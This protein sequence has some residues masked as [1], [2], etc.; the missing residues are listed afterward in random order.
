MLSLSLVAANA[1]TWYVDDD[2]T[3]ANNGTSWADAWTNVSRITVSALSAGD[4]VQ[5]A[6]GNYWDMPNLNKSGTAGS[7]I[8]I[9]MAQDTNYQG[10]VWL[11]N[12][13]TGLNLYAAFV[14]INGALDTDFVVP[15]AVNDIDVL[16]NNIGLHLVGPYGGITT[17]GNRDG[18]KLQWIHIGSVGNMD[19]SFPAD[20]EAPENGIYLG[21]PLT[22]AVIAYVWFQNTWFGDMINSPKTHT[23]LKVHDCLFYNMGDDPVQ[24]VG[25]F[26]L[27]RCKMKG[28]VWGYASGH[29][30]MIQTWGSNI[31][32]HHNI[33]TDIGPAFDGNGPNYT[34]WNA[35]GG[36]N[37]A[38]S[39][40]SFCYSNATSLTNPFLTS[41]TLGTK[42]SDFAGWLGYRFRTGTNNVVIT[43]LGRVYSTGETIPRVLRLY[44]STGDTATGTLRYSVTWDPSTD[45][46]VDGEM[47]YVTNG[48]YTL[49]A[50]TSYVLV[51]GEMQAGEEWYDYDTAVTSDLWAGGVQ[52]AVGSVSRY[53]SWGLCQFSAELDHDFMIYNN[54]LYDQSTNAYGNPGFGM[55]F[56]AYNFTTYYNEVHT[57]S[58][59]YFLNNLMQRPEGRPIGHTFYWTSGSARGSNDLFLMTNYVFG[60]N[61]IVDSYRIDSSQLGGNAADFPTVSYPDDPISG[62]DTGPFLTDVRVWTNVFCG[63]NFKLSGGKTNYANI[64]LA[65]ADAAFV[66]NQTNLPSFRRFDGYRNLPAQDFRLNRSDTVALDAGMNLTSLTNMMPDLDRDIDWN[67]RP[68][69]GAWDIGP[70]EYGSES[71]ILWLDFDDTNWLSSGRI[72]DMSG[73]ENH[74]Y[75]FGYGGGTNWPLVVESTNASSAASFNRWTNTSLS[76]GQEG[77]Y[78]GITNLTDFATNNTATFAVWCLFLSDTNTGSWVNEN[79]QSFVD[80]GY[81]YAGGMKWGKNGTKSVTIYYWTNSINTD[82]SAKEIMRWPDQTDTAGGDT[83]GWHHYAWTY[84]G[85]SVSAYYDGSFLSNST[86]DF[87]TATNLLMKGWL[88]VGCKTHYTVADPQETP[89]FGD[90]D[91]PN[92]GWLHANID[93]LRIYNTALSAQEINRV[94]LGGVASADAG[95]D[96]PPEPPAQTQTRRTRAGTLRFAF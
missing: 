51:G 23:N 17:S 50:N 20:G 10:H 15:D 75:Q 12:A 19:G 4:D 53:S 85:T 82:G 70:Y 74:A 21:D 13:T 64:V 38:W 57:I 84:N 93:D 24:V 81:G 56:D 35:R 59:V 94:Y 90:D 11:T 76:V 49:T 69:A 67:V 16:T 7:P 78:A 2:A 37:Q 62:S 71:L 44:E 47:L 14:E 34:E 26:E 42:R 22:N 45:G 96:D 83:N 41:V 95:E 27:Y 31:K 68:A 33:V 77:R 18:L 86:L 65:A 63:P 25:G 52:Y 40:V 9:R 36:T 58:N 88:A 6:E 89:E 32:F 1:T 79:N 54:V 8:V 30:D 46:A 66:G 48:S 43:G 72:T 61:I 29:P 60:N 5:L 39:P 28:H 73:R 87:L 92:H 3:G 55:T 91:Y 80:A